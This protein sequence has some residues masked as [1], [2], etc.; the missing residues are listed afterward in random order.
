M[1]STEQKKELTKFQWEFANENKGMPNI[2]RLRSSL[3]CG[4]FLH[5]SGRF[6]VDDRSL[7]NI[8][9]L[10]LRNLPNP[11]SEK[12][13]LTFLDGLSLRKEDYAEAVQ[14]LDIDFKSSAAPSSVGLSY[15]AYALLQIW[16]G[17]VVYDP[18]AGEGDFLRFASLE[19]ASRDHQMVLA[20]EEISPFHSN[21]AKMVMG[22]CS[23]N[24]YIECGD[25]LENTNIPNFEKC[26]LFPPIGAKLAQFQIG[27]LV[28]H[29]SE[30]LDYRT[31]GEWFYLFKAMTAESWKKI[32]MVISPSLLSNA[33]DAKVRK[34]LLEN[35]YVEGIVHLPSGTL[36]Y[37][38]AAIDLLVLSHWQKDEFR[39][40]DAEEKMKLTKK[41]SP[42]GLDESDAKKILTAYKGDK[43]RLFSLQNVDK[44]DYS[45]A[46]ASLLK[47][48]TYKNLK[49]LV[50]L[51][52]LAQVF[53]GSTK[54]IS[55]FAA[56]ANPFYIRK[57]SDSRILASTSISDEGIIDYASLDYVDMPEKYSYKAAKAGDL[58]MT[59]KSSK[60]KIA[61]VD[62]NFKGS[63][64][65][66]GGMNIIRPNPELLDATYL[67]MLFESSKGKTLLSTIQKGSIVTS[68]S[69]NDLKNLEIPC[70]PIK[71][72]K[73]AAKEYKDLL[74]QC[75]AMKKQLA[76]T[77][78]KISK[79]YDEKFGKE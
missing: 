42:N 67:K 48:E 69:P 31:S 53:A 64:V 43:T 18:L 54:T 11:R 16:K 65:T 46:K 10:E 39:Y 50:P 58:I 15:L 14:F 78:K 36:P 40:Y 73:A 1:L 60:L 35:G 77:Q 52:R 12:M 45:L 26:Y 20:G 66:T 29:Y 28:T 74:K 23:G 59:S 33:R 44:S 22:M 56:A 62:E 70:P 34:Y 25:F 7:A 49:N 37:H 6:H 57:K 38:N 63:L 61:I 55:D 2:S 32:V 75:E 19:A 79:V 13:I 71:D 4:F 24:N 76:A 51:F 3:I 8:A 9:S 30:A 21:I 17:N 68:I 47:G 27:S 41:Y 72:Q 5:Y